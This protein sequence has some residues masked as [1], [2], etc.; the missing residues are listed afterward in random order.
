MRV[1]CE[2]ASL[3]FAVFGALVVCAPAFAA[4]GVQRVP[5]NHVTSD[6]FIRE[7]LVVG[8]FPNRRIEGAAEG[9]VSRE[10]F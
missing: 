4:G 10:G 7:W 9:A 3:C 6:G 5:V 2:F 1:S 8:S